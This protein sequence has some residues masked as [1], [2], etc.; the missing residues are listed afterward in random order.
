MNDIR[1][2]QNK[3]EEILKEFKIH[4]IPI[5][6]PEGY[7]IS[8]SA[9]RK[10]IP[11]EM[12]EEMAEK[13]CKQYYQLYKE[14]D[15]Q[16]STEKKH[17]SMF[18]NIDYNCIPDKYSGLKE[19]VK[20]I[21]DKYQDL[22]KNCLHIWSANANGIDIQANS[23][24]NPKIPKILNGEDIYMSSR[25]HNILNISHPGP[26]N[27]PF[28]MEKG[29]KIENEA[30][31]ISS[32]LESLQKQGTLFAY[33]NYHSA[34][35]I[36][37]Q[38]PAIVEDEMDIDQDSILKKEIV[39]YIFAKIYQERTYK[40]T[41]TTQNGEDKRDISKYIIHTKE[42]K[43]TSTNDFFRLAYP[44]D[45][46]IEL[47][48]MGGNPIG[49]YGDIKGNYTNAMISNLEAVKY[50]LDIACVAQMIAESSY[51]VIK[52]IDSQ[53]EYEKIIEIQDMIYKEFSKNI[54]KM[55]GV[56]E[57]SKEDYER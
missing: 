21:L 6:N 27:C 19:S 11:R 15:L 49:P 2:K 51:K 3:W 23:K 37:F 1:K 56:G 34:G 32:L 24:L 20:N 13:I 35:G 40:N 5:L 36:I 43:A 50:T 57:K 18:E 44:K 4:I 55:Q 33:L 39:N 25:R 52:K 30:N 7:L 38:R 14:D 42:S 54:K 28:D 17:I 8:T 31:A 16:D 41:G 53:A 12:S 10:L 29:F 22:P 45:L 26:I 47:S 46:L 9:I 48:G